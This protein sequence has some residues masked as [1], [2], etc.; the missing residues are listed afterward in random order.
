MNTFVTV[1]GWTCIA[2]LC[3]GAAAI[4]VGIA[5]RACHRAF[6]NYESA[7]VLKCRHALGLDLRSCAHWFSESKETYIAIQILGERIRDGYGTDVS[8]W[9]EEWHEKL[10]SEGKAKSEGE[11]R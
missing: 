3:I 6:E 5:A 4:A 2:M 1:V 10:R 8:R 11:S 7:V 9:R